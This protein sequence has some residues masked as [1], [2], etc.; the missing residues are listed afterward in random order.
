L[1]VLT[2]DEIEECVWVV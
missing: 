2:E 1:V